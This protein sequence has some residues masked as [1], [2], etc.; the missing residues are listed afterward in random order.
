MLKSYRGIVFAPDFNYDKAFSD[1]FPLVLSYTETPAGYE[2]VFTWF[3]TIRGRRYINP[4]TDEI[5]KYKVMPPEEAAA[6]YREHGAQAKVTLERQ[7]DGRLILT[8][9][10]ILKPYDEIPYTREEFTALRL[11]ALEKSTPGLSGKLTR[12]N[13]ASGSPT[14]AYYRG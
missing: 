8:S 11:A 6:W 2:A 7:G 3:C 10:E 4:T 9:L 1:A 14:A 5:D 12:R 13:S